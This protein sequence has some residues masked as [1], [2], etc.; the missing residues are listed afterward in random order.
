MLNQT[1]N[2]YSKSVLFGVNDDIKL[3]NNIAKKIL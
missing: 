3:I 2:V 1:L